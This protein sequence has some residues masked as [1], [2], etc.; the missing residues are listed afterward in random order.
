MF[1][2]QD[3]YRSLSSQDQ[4]VLSCVTRLLKDQASYMVTGRFIYNLR[5]KINSFLSYL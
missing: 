1:L 4:V 2:F 3:D 5:S